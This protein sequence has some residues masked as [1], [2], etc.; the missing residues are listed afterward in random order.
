[1]SGR[2]GYRI[3]Y[4]ALVAGLLWACAPRAP[5]A[6]VTA[7]NDKPAAPVTPAA[8]SP[9]QAA[10]PSTAPAPSAPAPA[11]QAPAKPS[12]QA[13]TPPKTAAATA[14]EISHGRSVYNRAC[15]MCHGPNGAG[16]ANGPPPLTASKKDVA[17]IKSVI[18]NGGGTMPPMGAL[19][20]AEE[21]DAV[22]KFSVAGFPAG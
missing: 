13:A 18:A 8:P 19:L 15:V 7:E 1:M 17:G 5:E 20:T 6:P 9:E 14:D 4:A 3:A 16:I 12:Q 21:I 10:Q 22:A 11:P 2:N